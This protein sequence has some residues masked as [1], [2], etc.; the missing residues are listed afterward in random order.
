MAKKVKYQVHA[1]TIDTNVSAVQE[2]SFPVDNGFE[3]CDGVFA[4]MTDGTS[5]FSMQLKDDNVVHFEDVYSVM[6]EPSKNY[7]QDQ[8]FLAA[9][10]PGKNNR[11]TVSVK[12]LGALAVDTKTLHVVLRL[13]NK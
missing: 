12:W 9:D 5:T 2:T 3:A 11:M 13:K 6:F 10:I 4:A 7:P 8:R 1:M